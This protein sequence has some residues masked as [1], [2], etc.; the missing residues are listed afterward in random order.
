MNEQDKHIE[1]LEHQL[2]DEKRKS[3]DAQ[4]LKQSLCEGVVRLVGHVRTCMRKAA[5]NPDA[6]EFTLR[7]FPL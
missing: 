3:E 2:E 1:T 7:F 4:R 6:V 5:L